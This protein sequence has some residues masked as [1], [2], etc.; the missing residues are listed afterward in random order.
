MVAVATIAAKHA[1]FAN[2]LVAAND[3]I[4]AKH[5]PF[6]TLPISDCHPDAHEPAKTPASLN[7][8]APNMAHNNMLP[9]HTNK[10]IPAPIRIALPSILSRSKICIF[11]ARLKND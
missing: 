9:K 1:Q 2:N 8:S 5:V 7:P 10:T 3:C 4:K 6:A 11:Y